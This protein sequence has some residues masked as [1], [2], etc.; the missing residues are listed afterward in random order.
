V[1]ADGGE[2]VEGS[3]AACL[4]IFSSLLVTHTGHPSL[5]LKVAWTILSS[6]SEF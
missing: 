2:C 3:G 1:G 6:L 4:Q 5:G